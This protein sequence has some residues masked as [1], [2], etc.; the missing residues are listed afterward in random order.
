MW[1]LQLNAVL[2]SLVV[3]IGLWVLAGQLS[4]E[5]ALFAT[6]AVAIF[7]LWVGSQVLSIWAWATLLLGL[8]S[9]TWPV[10]LMVQVKQSGIEP[11]DEQMTTLLTAM[12]FGLFSSIFW[13]TFSYGLFRW[14]ARSK[15]SANSAALAASAA[16]SHLEGSAKKS[17]KKRH[18]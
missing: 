11:T 6:L 17:R 12:L 15:A 16:Q 4:L 2:G 18:R 7:L 8:E 9:L 3:T 10:V 5:F 14:A 1:I 13:L